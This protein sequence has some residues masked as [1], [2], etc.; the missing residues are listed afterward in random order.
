MPVYFE[1]RSRSTPLRERS[2]AD[3]LSEILQDAARSLNVR[4]V[5]IRAASRDAYL[6]ACAARSL[7]L[8]GSIVQAFRSDRRLRNFEF[9]SEASTSDGPFRWEVSTER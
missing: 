2:S 8:V 6:Y 7:P 5:S 9:S 1:M 3:A 4:V